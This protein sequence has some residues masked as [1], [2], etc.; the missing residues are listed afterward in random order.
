MELVKEYVETLIT[1]NY[2]FRKSHIELADLD[3]QIEIYGDSHESIGVYRD[4][5]TNTK[6]QLAEYERKLV[7]LENEFCKG[8]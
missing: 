2:L 4:K 3:D 5:F 8:L 7:R 1:K 6:K